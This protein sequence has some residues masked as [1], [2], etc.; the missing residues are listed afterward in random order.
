MCLHLI[1]DSIRGASD[2]SRA[3][4]VPA[5]IS[6]CECVERRPPPEQSP[7]CSDRRRREARAGLPRALTAWRIEHLRIRPFWKTVHNADRARIEDMASP[8]GL[9]PAT[10]W[11]V[12]VIR[13]I[14]RY[15][16]G[17][18]NIRR[19]SDLPTIYALQSTSIDLHRGPSSETV[20]SQTASHSAHAESIRLVS[21]GYSARGC[22]LRPLLADSPLRAGVRT[23]AHLKRLDA[24]LAETTAPASR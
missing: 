17:T 14:H 24:H 4:F 13:T 11:F 10:S 3:R 20:A 7:S 21:D 9:E 15:R 8:G 2:S 6:F 16:Q 22:D 5:R 18:M 12:E 23:T 19:L 1:V